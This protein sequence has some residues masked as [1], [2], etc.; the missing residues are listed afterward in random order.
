MAFITKDDFKAV[1]DPA[2]LEVIDQTDNDNL[3][4]AIG[5]AKEEVASYLRSRYDVDKAFS[6]EGNDR[7]PQLVMILCDVALYHLVAWL[8]KRIGFEIRETRYNNAISWLKDVQSGKATPDL[9]P[10]TND[11]GED[12]GNPVRYGGWEKSEYMY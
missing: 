10:L 7:N 6:K 5:Y 2:T 8:P 12:I 4:R 9:D 1:C 3:N 11:K